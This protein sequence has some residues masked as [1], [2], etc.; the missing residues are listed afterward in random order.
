MAAKKGKTTVVEDEDLE[1]EE[2]ADDDDAVE[3]KSAKQDVTFGVSH[4]AEH[5]SQKTG[6]KVTTRELRTLIRKMARDGSN[7]VDREITAGNRTRYDWPKGLKDPEVKAII[8]A[9]TGGE[10]EEGKKAALAALK[11]RKAAKKADA[12]KAGKSKG[13]SKKATKVEVED[14]DEIEDLELE[15]DED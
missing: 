6:K 10:M 9:V 7:R 3:T 11:E 5:L 12:E 8:A 1:L 13:K 2:L 14:D 15:D 4:L